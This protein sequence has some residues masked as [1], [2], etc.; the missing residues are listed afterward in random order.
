MVSSQFEFPVLNFA[1]LH[2]PGFFFFFF[3]CYRRITAKDKEALQQE[4][5]FHFLF[6]FYSLWYA[7]WFALHRGFPHLELFVLLED[8]HASYILRTAPFIQMLPAESANYM[9]PYLTGQ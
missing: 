4:R 5:S 6:L 1:Q 9:R 8:L 7:P 2:I 3:F